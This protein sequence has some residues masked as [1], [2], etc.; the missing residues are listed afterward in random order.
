MADTKISALTAATTPLAGTEVLPIVQSGVTKQVSVA[1]LTAGRAVSMSSATV[2]GLTSGRIT[3]A[4]TGGLLGD[5]ANFTYNGTQL[6]VGQTSYVNTGVSGQ[7]TGVF[8]SL[9]LGGQASGADSIYFRRT[10]TAGYYQIQT[11]DGGA[12]S[13]ILE[14][15]P[16]GGNVQI[17]AGNLVIGT[18]GNGLTSTGAMTVKSSS[19]GANWQVYSSA[20]ST[21]PVYFVN[22]SGTV[23]GVATGANG[24]AAM[25][26][27]NKDSG[28]LRSINAAG[29]L[30]ASGADYAEYELKND[31]CGVISKGQIVGF[32]A[33]GKLTD[34]W[35][36]AKSFAVKTTNPSYVG[37]DTWGNNDV[38]GVAPECPQYPQAIG[39]NEAPTQEQID[40]YQT[41][42]DQYQTDLAAWKEKL[43]VERQKVDRIAY[44]GKVPC[45]VNGAKVGDYIIAVQNGDAIDGM[46]VEAPTFDQYRFA[47]GKVRAI[48]SDGRCEIAVIIH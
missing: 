35:A 37:G 5:S 1:N 17:G 28:N 8:Q 34:K 42:F 25:L 10:G 9:V 33:D 45:N 13:G 29:T 26:Y 38:V 43:E 27:V 19:G 31:A 22:G 23:N 3:F 32:D 4:G 41:A 39:E 40:Q 24:T 48:L 16:Y 6:L 7:A 20:S 14:L 21:N 46:A 11:T 2:S 15:Q 18:S 36:Q 30:N 44:A 47:V 12:S